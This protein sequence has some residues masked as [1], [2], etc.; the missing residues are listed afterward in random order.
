M[1]GDAGTSRLRDQFLGMDVAVPVHG[2][3]TRPYVNLDAAASTP[4]LRRVAAAVSAFAPHYSS[5]HRGAGW[6]SRVA[7]AAYEEAREIV[8]GFVGADA[9][10]EVVFVKHTTEAIN[11]VAHSLRDRGGAVVATEM[12]HHA[13]LLPWR[14]GGP[15]LVL[16]A[17]GAA[18]PIDADAVEE[19]LRRAARPALLAVTAASNVTGE[20]PDIHGL[21]ALAHR[22]GARILVDAAQLVAHRPITCLPA[23]DER[24]LDFVAFSGHKMY[25]PYGCGVL[26]APRDAL[27][28]EPLLAGGGAVEL[29]THDETVWSGG[30]AGAEAGSPNV[31][32]AVALA[33]AAAWLRDECG[34]PRLAAHE[35]DVTEQLLSGLRSVAGVRLLGPPTA[36]GRLGACSFV[37]DGI[38]GALVA[39]ILSWEWGIGVRHGC[40]CAH[41]YLL[42][43]LH[44]SPADIERAR[45][46]A[47]RGERRHLPGAVRASVGAFAT[48]ADVDRLVEALSAVARGA[49][50]AEYVQEE[51]GEYR[52]LDAPPPPSI[53]QLLG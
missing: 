36:E 3:G 12:E 42:H 44:L 23:S 43:L 25:A 41:P 48:G 26:V 34:F 33:E 49:R 5:V 1:N 30:A 51:S 39:S 19:A 50:N 10:Q 46:E 4:P 32:G 35:R 47:R 13:N 37:V 14:H 6:P 20:M 17:I 52:A 7:T 22:H 38:P 21:A 2:G 16:L 29:V 8:R 40:F 53:R 45:D 24:H 31:I 18:A 11:I 9:S 15:G 27:A 28:G